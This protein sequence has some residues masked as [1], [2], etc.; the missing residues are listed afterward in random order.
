MFKNLQQN[1][2][3]KY[4]GI[5]FIFILH[6]L[7]K[8]IVRFKY[9]E[10]YVRYNLTININY[11]ENSSRYIRICRFC[12]TRLTEILNSIDIPIRLIK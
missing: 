12:F 2:A 5:L 1:I 7:Y 10:F 9:F 4:E 3:L 6:K 11:N 8:F